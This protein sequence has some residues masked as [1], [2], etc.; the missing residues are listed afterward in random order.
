MAYLLGAAGTVTYEGQAAAELEAK[1]WRALKP[2]AG[3]HP[4]PPGASSAETAA[5]TAAVAPEESPVVAA[6]GQLRLSHWVNALSKIGDSDLAALAFHTGLA[7]GLVSWVD[8]ALATH[9]AK[10]IVLAG[11]CFQNRLLRETLLTL[12]QQRGLSVL[13]PDKVPANDHAISL[14]Q[15]WTVATLQLKGNR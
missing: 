12:L 2:Q 6:N 4:R 8:W 10:S 9:P 3:K 13:L 7:Q 15:A 11:G 14:G 1:A 5:I